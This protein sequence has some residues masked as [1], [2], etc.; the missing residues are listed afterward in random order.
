M[1]ETITS[2]FENRIKITSDDIAL[3]HKENGSWQPTTWKTYGERVDR[4]AKGL[5]AAGVKNGDKV[6]LIGANTPSWFIADMAI[7]TM[8]AVSVPIYATSSGE[9]IRHILNHSESKV[10]IVEEISYYRRVEKMLGEIPM[11]VKVVVLKGGHDVSAALLTDLTSFEKEGDNLSNNDLSN[12]RED[13]ASDTIC[14]FIYTSGTTGPPKAV[15]LTHKNCFAAA[16][17]VNLTIRLKSEEKISAS[18]L[19]LSHVAERVVNLYA[20]LLDGRIVYFMGGFNTFAEDLKEIRPTLW[21]GVPRVWEKIYEGVMRQRDNFP[22][23]QQKVFDEALKVASR[24]NWADHNKEH[25]SDK[26]KARYEDAKALVIDNLLAGLG[27][28][29]V[30]V[31]VTGG[32]PTSEEILDFFVSI[33]IRLQDVYGQTEGHGTTSFATKGDIKFGSAGKPFPLVDIKIAEDG[34][35]LVKGDNVSLGYYK[36]PAATAETFKDGWLYSG[37][38]G[39]IDTDGYLWIT[40][41]KK[42]IIITSGGKNITPSKIEAS[43]MSSS[44]VEHAVVVGDGRKYLSAL[45]SV[46][47]EAGREFIE[48]SGTFDV[49]QSDHIKAAIDKHV[50]ETNQKFSRV[51]QIKKYTLVPQCFSI[52]N[53]ELTHT[54]KLKKNVIIKRYENEID[55]MY[56]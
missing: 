13:V 31:A 40:G 41:R 47:N 38:L 15:M 49:F 20:T 26:L 55:E 30:E 28:D 4:F 21:M 52:E 35:I 43:L 32:A 27:L 25:I 34:E 16:E 17:N 36:D 45:I 22:E 46:N 29:R 24:H 19:P 10:F 39:L 50:K 48:S 9:Q 6:A 7:M 14:T 53:G 51:E 12:A 1:T 56:R 33:D 11:L 54:Q 23:T 18:Y 44:L 3:Y 8:G 37:D 42:D 5:I 2:L